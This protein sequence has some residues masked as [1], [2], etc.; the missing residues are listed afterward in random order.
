MKL[1]EFFKPKEIITINKEQEQ[2][3]ELQHIKTERPHKGHTLFKVC[4]KTKEITK[5]EFE[6]EDVVFQNVTSKKDVENLVKKKKVII[7][8]GY[9]Y[10]LA[11]NKKNVI[12]KLNKTN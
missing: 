4:K 6:Q 12:K 11:L 3:T 5:A 1:D 2:K 10:I 8:E 9:D 7:E